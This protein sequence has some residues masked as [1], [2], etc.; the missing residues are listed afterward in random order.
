MAIENSSRSIATKLA[1]N[2]T[3]TEFTTPGSAISILEVKEKAGCFAIIV[4][5]IYC[6]Y[7][8]SV[9]V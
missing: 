9:A 5:Q 6:Y 3:G 1:A 7:K 8:R 4:L 2:R